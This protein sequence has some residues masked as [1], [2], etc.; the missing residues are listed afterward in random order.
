MP[1]DAALSVPTAIESSGLDLG[2]RSLDL[3]AVR[4]ESTSAIRP[5]RDAAPTPENLFPVKRQIVDLPAVPGLTP[6]AQTTAAPTASCNT[7][8]PHSQMVSSNRDACSSVMETSRQSALLPTYPT[9]DVQYFDCVHYS[10]FPDIGQGINKAL[11][12]VG[13]GGTVMIS[14]G[15]IVGTVS[16]TIT[17]GKNQSLICD[18]ATVLQPGNS[19]VNM[20]AVGVGATVRGCSINAT[21]E[22][23]YSGAV[24]SLAGNYRD[25]SHTSLSDIM[26]NAEGNALC[27]GILMSASN[28]DESIAFVSLMN[29]R[30]DG[31]NNGVHLLANGGWINGNQFQDIHVSF[32]VHAFNLENRSDAIGAT[33]SGNECLNCSS[34]KGPLSIDSI[35]VT[36]VKPG[37]NIQNMFAPFTAWDYLTAISL[38]SSAA[39]NVFMG[40]WDGTISDPTHLNTYIT[41]GQDA[42]RQPGAY[43]SENATDSFVATTSSQTQQKDMHLSN[44]GGNLYIGVDNA[45]GS[46]FGDPYGSVWYSPNNNSYFV[47][48]VSTFTGTVHQILTVSDGGSAC[49]NS[50]LSLSHGWGESASVSSVMGTG[51]TCQWTIAAEGTTSANPTITDT[52]TNVLP[53]PSTVCD[54]HMVGGTG[55][56]TLVQE[57]TFSATAPVF[58]FNGTPSNGSTY[59]VVRR[60]GP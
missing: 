49:S 23:A 12:D 57:T 28:L 59:V 52:L 20:I 58:T 30:I 25:N 38:D 54:M 18:P 51:Q 29:I 19:S 33:I 7:S 16:T 17:V 44:A 37:E 35:H 56:A 8:Q 43:I 14:L 13:N 41:S 40:R 32:A 24:L 34:Q 1:S 55:L 47:T 53:S 21:N 36:G 15:A 10:C 9:D 6:L 22:G 3:G 26:I 31:C 42:I 11:S 48:P 4:E 50:E 5:T 39:F 2:S 46:A 27:D 60:C 45:T